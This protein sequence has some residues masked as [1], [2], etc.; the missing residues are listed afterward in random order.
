M[1]LG[2]ETSC[3]IPWGRYATRRKYMKW[4]KLSLETT[5]EAV[6][7]VCDMLLSLGI[8]GIEVVDKVPI[9]EE[10]KKKMFIDILPEL[11]ED[12]GIAIVN[13]Y[14]EKEDDLPSLEVSIKEGL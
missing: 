10:E 4:K 2:Y 5:T 7:L 12:D 6:D 9:T 13:F 11:G 14:L 1:N 8:E 3:F